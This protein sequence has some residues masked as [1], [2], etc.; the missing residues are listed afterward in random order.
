MREPPA[1]DV[2]DATRRTRLANERT[3]LAWWRGGLTA[4]AVSVGAGAL[5]PDVAS[6]RRWPFVL[7]GVAFG[8]LA[9]AFIVVGTWR[10]R[11]VE[12][13]LARGRFSPLGERAAAVIGIAGVALGALTILV[14]T[15]AT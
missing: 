13:A 11:R 6:V 15:L 2:A 1:E 8:V 9:I 4:L 3:Y 12:R 14:V 7:L 5:V 10:Y